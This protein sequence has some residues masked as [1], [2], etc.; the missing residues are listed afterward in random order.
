MTPEHWNNKLHCEFKSYKL[1]EESFYSIIIS[2][3][4]N[5]AYW[6][7]AF[8]LVGYFSIFLIKTVW[9]S[10]TKQIRKIFVRFEAAQNQKSWLWVL[11]LQKHCSLR[12]PQCSSVVSLLFLINIPTQ[13]DIIPM[14]SPWHHHG[15]QNLLRRLREKLSST[16][17]IFLF[18]I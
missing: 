11:E 4:H 6:T 8:L 16:F 10:I 2:C 12:F 7:S 9:G 5:S 3:F 18:I 17:H 15:Q 14:T 1:H 13:S